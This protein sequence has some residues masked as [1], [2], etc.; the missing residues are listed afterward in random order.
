MAISTDHHRLSEAKTE[1]R[2]NKQDLNNQME[3]IVGLEISLEIQEREFEKIREASQKFIQTKLKRRR[4][5][6][7]LDSNQLEIQQLD[8]DLSITLGKKIFKFSFADS[9]QEKLKEKLLNSS[10]SRGQVLSSLIKLKD[11][12]RIKGLYETIEVR[13]GWN[14]CAKRIIYTEK[15]LSSYESLKWPKSRAEKD[16]IKIEISLAKSEGEL[17]ELNNETEKL[18][19]EIQQKTEISRSIHSLSKLTFHEI[20]GDDKQEFQIYTDDELDS[21]D[22]DTIQGEIDDLKEK[23]QNA[24]PNLSVFEDYRICE[25]EYL[26]SVR[27]FEEITSKRDECKKGW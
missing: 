2:F 12:S 16:R 20:G 15:E 21:M 18:T 8:T 10:Q 19:K 6:L 14:A 7:H 5:N 1:L 23:I 9:R 22:K 4:E 13:D 27:D 3:K 11:S 25:K 24:N 26:A 17:E